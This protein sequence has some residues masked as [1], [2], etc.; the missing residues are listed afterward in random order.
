MIVG[1][2][3][4]MN[5]NYVAIGG[6][7]TRDP[8]LTKVGARDTS[9]V[10]FGIAVNEKYKSHDG[11][12][13][14]RVVFVDVAAWARKA[15]VI[16]EYLSKGDPI[17]VEGRLEFSTWTDKAGV[18]R[19]KLSIVA[20]KFQFIGPKKDDAAAAPSGNPAVDGDVPF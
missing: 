10:K 9:L 13:K 18:N 7:L 5:H 12:K 20:E 4:D 3:S 19:S 6:H 1:Y 15:E 14:E 11:V 16:H 8:E 17:F 2:T